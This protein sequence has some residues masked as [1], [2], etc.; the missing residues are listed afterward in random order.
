[1]RLINISKQDD[2]NIKKNE[3][4]YMDFER[5]KDLIIQ[6][7]ILGFSRGEKDLSNLP[8]VHAV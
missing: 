1:V 3:V 7:G 8:P 5:F 6:V 2:K 4:R